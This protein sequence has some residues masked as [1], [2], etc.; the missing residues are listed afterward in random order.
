MRRINFRKRTKVKK[1]VGENREGRKN[2]TQ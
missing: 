2:L 1:M